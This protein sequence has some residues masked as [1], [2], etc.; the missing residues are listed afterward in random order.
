MITK[1]LIQLRILPRWIIIVLDLFVVGFSTYLAYLLRFNFELSE[2][3]KFNYGLGIL[4][5]TSACLL[6][7]LATKSYAGIVR[8][9]G[10]HDGVRVLSTLLITHIATG[11]VNY[12]FNLYNGYNLLPY[13]VILISL[14]A[15]FVFLFQYRLLIKNIFSY[16][17][18]PKKG[19]KLRVAIF[20]AG[21]LGMITKQVLDNSV[22]PNFRI[23]AFIE[24]DATK[25]GKVINGTEIYYGVDDL[26]SLIE[27]LDIK[28]LIIAASRLSLD[29]KNAI[30][31]ACLSQNVR[32]RTIPE[33]DDWVK[34]E[35][36][37]NQIKQVNIEDLLGRESIQLNNKLVWDQLKGKKVCIT[38]AAGSIGSELVRQVIQY[39]PELVILIDQA[40]SALYEVEREIASSEKDSR[41]KFCVADITNKKRIKEIFEIDQPDILFH[42]AAY[43]HVPM[44]ERNPAEAVLCNVI[45]TRN[46]ANLAIEYGTEKFVMIS[47]DKAVNPTNVMGCSKRI[48]EIYV[49]AL[50]NE[51][52]KAE[53]KASKTSFVTTRF[54]NVLGS[55]GSV[56]PFFE[57]QI[58]EGGP[59]TVTHPDITRY[60]MTITEACQLVLEAG[61]MGNGGE[62]F[63]FDM[64]QSM[65]IVDLAKKMIRLSGL[66]LDKD[67]EIVFTGLRQGEKLYEELLASKENTQPTHHHK[68]MIAKVLE[69][70]YQEISQSVDKL[71]ELA[72]LAKSNFDIVGVMKSIV[73]EFK[74]KS[75]EYEILDDVLSES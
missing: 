36:S 6:A 21:Q 55:N 43:K 75:S 59:V 13:S 12:G 1:F 41:Y 35:L 31:D 45:G 68:I 42:A 14:L 48:A 69:Y 5:N 57:K 71:H 22:E 23:V 38:G 65:K 54:G 32:V 44:M 51:L 58:K 47:T 18:G 25:V 4:I 29:R 11:L 10:L 72:K 30:V 40:E 64:G 7:L 62:I 26:A 37:V 49:R 53:N 17:R 39:D 3:Y 46:L 19:D 56:I 24:D 27:E 34:G 8:Y 60:F 52:R 20:G 73:P 74:S 16:Y 67:I 33:V 63:I 61:A 2:L 9:T 70:D 66:E 50:N 28:E 15:S